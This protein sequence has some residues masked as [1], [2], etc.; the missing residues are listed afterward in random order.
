MKIT[1]YILLIFFTLSLST[2]LLVAKSIDQPIVITFE[3]NSHI[4]TATLEELIGAKRPSSYIFW[5]DNIATIN[6]LYIKKLDEI[7]TLFYRQEGF[8]ESHIVHTIDNNGIHFKIDE[9]R[10]IIIESI[11]VKSDFD[12]STVIYLKE[13]SRFRSKDFGRTKSAINK[14]LLKNGYCRHDLNTKAYI[15]LERYSAKITIS[16][17]QGKICHFGKINID[18]SGSIEDKLILSRLHFR[19]GEVFDPYK[20]KESYE[21]LYALDALDSLYMVYSTKFDENIPIDIH[22]K[23]IG[24]NRSSRIGIGYATD[25]NFQANYHREYRNFYGGGRKLLF[26]LLFSQ[27]QKHIKSN[28][29]NPAVL[30]LWGYHIDFQNSLGYKEEH[31]IHNFD[32]KVAYD[33][34]Y[35]QHR[36][37]KW[38]HS[39][40]VGVENI[41]ISNDKDFFLIYPFMN[42][43]YDVRDSKINPKKGIYFSHKMELGLPYSPD[44]TTYLKY[45][46]ELRLI[47]S[48]SPVTFSAV[49]RVG[50]IEVYDNRL[51]ESKKFFAGG[52]FSNRAYGYDKIG[53][54]TTSREDSD[55]G[56][57]SIVNLSLEV[58]FPI[59]KDV[60][61]GIFTDSSMV[62]SKQEFWNFDDDIIHSVGL[63]VRYMTP[64]GPFKVDFGVNTQ[65][66]SQN[67][68]HFQI[69][70][71]F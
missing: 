39:V 10:P 26:D 65:D 3:G 23:E 17:K 27:K 35:L 53:I 7:F 21:S 18:G 61:M 58:N 45:L 13:H 1:E 31:D 34:L 62:S 6:E 52:A 38:L 70:Q 44:S 22:F 24:K 68:L 46:E 42:I 30:N 12:I 16:L 20:I 71:S 49:G 48:I 57:S 40:G 50:A 11:A 15:D 32:E 9:K 4:E 29:F 5:K 60:Y 8:Y 43:I 36:D 59:Y 28:F 63:G 67:G 51:P 47:Y 55:L 33:K 54:T 25:L 69:G 2:K 56:G 14:L 37:D 64:L 19:E 66:Y 41:Q